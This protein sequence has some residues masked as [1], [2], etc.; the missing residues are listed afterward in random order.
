MTGGWLLAPR[1]LCALCVVEC[2]DMKEMKKTKN[3]F[4]DGGIQAE[5]VMLQKRR[6]K[7]GNML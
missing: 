3:F 2:R 1:W 4:R 6:A 5:A 7:W